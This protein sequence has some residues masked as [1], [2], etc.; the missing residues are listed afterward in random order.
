VKSTATSFVVDFNTS[1]KSA[2]VAIT[3]TMFELGVD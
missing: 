3:V 2:L 1:S